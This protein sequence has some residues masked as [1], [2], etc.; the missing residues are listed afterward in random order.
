MNQPTDDGLWPMRDLVGVRNGEAE[1]GALV[2]ADAIQIADQAFGD[3]PWSVV[4]FELQ[5]A[6]REL[7]SEAERLD[8][9]RKGL[10]FREAS[11][12]GNGSSVCYVESLPEVGRDL[13]LDDVSASA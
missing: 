10:Y 6:V 8:W 9:A 12:A 1:V 11:V 2:D 5:H 3:G 7:P 13:L 4:G